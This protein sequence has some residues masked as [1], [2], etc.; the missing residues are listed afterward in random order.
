MGEN[1]IKTMILVSEN[2]LSLIIAIE[3]NEFIRDF[4]VLIEIR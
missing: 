3:R 2:I 4:L 1:H